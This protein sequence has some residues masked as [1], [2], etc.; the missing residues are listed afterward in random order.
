MVKYTKKRVYLDLPYIMHIK[1]TSSIK[2]GGNIIINHPTSLSLLYEFTF[3]KI[4]TK[5]ILKVD[6]KYPHLL[7]GKFVNGDTFSLLKKLNCFI[8]F[9]N[10]DIII[11]LRGGRN[12][13]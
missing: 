12:K 3:K 5:Q 6:Q 10:I 7:G 2:M 9:R 8:I 1:P 13:N 4:R 11:V